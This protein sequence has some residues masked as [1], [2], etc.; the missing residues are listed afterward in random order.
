MASYFFPSSP[1]DSSGAFH[2]W[3]VKSTAAT[4]SID[5]TTIRGFPS[6][7]S[8]I[9]ANTLRMRVMTPDPRRSIHCRAGMK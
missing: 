3:T 7:N 8:T 5:A 6:M 9:R 4:K 2:V 1:A